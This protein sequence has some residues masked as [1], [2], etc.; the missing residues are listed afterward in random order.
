MAW[1]CRYNKAVSIWSRIRKP[2]LVVWAILIPDM[3]T[4]F[5]PRGEKTPMAL[6]RHVT[7]WWNLSVNRSADIMLR[8]L[9][10]KPSPTFWGFAENTHPG[11]KVTSVDS[12]SFSSIT[13]WYCITR[14]HTDA[15]CHPS[16]VTIGD[17]V[18]IRPMKLI[19]FH[20]ILAY[21]H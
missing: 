13:H 6:W 16:F 4:M 15:I 12:V 2:S 8:Y 1:P 21:G 18:E 14:V 7:W 19:H 3:Q 17:Y 9:R 11:Q 10:K 20:I 5:T